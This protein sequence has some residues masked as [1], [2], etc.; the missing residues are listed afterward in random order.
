MQLFSEIPILNLM[1]EMWFKTHLAVS[2]RKLDLQ[3]RHER[4]RNVDNRGH[5]HVTRIWTISEAH[6]TNQVDMETLQT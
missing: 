4:R 5:E 1:E 3:S 2:F 6:F